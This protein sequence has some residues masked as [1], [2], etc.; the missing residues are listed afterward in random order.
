MK[1]CHHFGYYI[2]LF[3]KQN[4]TNN[5]ISTNNT[6]ED[7]LS[8]LIKEIFLWVAFWKKNTW[9]FYISLQITD[10]D[11]GVRSFLRL[12]HHTQSE[13]EMEAWWELASFAHFELNKALLHRYLGLSCICTSS[14]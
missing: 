12:F 1:S 3:S 7:G 14:N 6:K 5:I 4:H 13:R 2:F 9:E 10:T 11:R 8:I